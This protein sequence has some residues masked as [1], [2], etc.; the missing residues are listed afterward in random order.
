MQLDRYLEHAT[1]AAAFTLLTV[2]GNATV[3]DTGIVWSAGT[4]IVWS[5]VLLLLT[6]P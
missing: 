4:G 2:M 6:P 3:A 1:I 5:I